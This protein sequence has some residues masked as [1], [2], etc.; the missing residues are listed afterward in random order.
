MESE[1]M[2]RMIQDFVCLC[3]KIAVDNGIFH[4]YIINTKH[5][6][7]RN[8]FSIKLSYG[9][10]RFILPSTIIYL[11]LSSTNEPKRCNEKDKQCRL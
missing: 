8:N 11:A 3:W 7:S 10:N 5:R 2:T 1:N 6:D 9:L 4:R